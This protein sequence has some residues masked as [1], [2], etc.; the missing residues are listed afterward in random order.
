[1][2]ASL[3]MVACWC[4]S[5]SLLLLHTLG[6]WASVGRSRHGGLSPSRTTLTDVL[7]CIRTLRTPMPGMYRFSTR[8]GR[9][10]GCVNDTDACAAARLRAGLCGPRAANWPSFLGRGPAR[11]DALGVAFLGRVGERSDL[12]RRAVGLEAPKGSMRWLTALATLV[13]R[14]DE[15]DDADSGDE[16]LLRRVRREMGEVGDGGSGVLLVSDATTPSAGGRFFVPAPSS[17]VGA[18]AVLDTEGSSSNHDGAI[19]GSGAWR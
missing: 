16:P 3:S 17:P 18:D 5:A 4:W 14:P 6:V 10:L 8:I 2:M 13:A 19:P 9:F 12:T 7:S 11:A 15:G 1:M